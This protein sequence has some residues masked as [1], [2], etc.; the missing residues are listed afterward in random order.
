MPGRRHPT[1]L[2]APGVPGIQ[3]IADLD[4]RVL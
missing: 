4:V 1:G 3:F 2:P